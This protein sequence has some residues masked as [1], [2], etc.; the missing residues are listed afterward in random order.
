M[1]GFSHIYDV[2]VSILE[3]L[4]TK[5]APDKVRTSML[6]AVKSLFAVMKHDLFFPWLC[7]D[8]PSW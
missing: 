6:Q 1:Y 2:I 8:F 3:E 7:I 5:E 4:F